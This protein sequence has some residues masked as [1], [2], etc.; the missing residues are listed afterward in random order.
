MGGRLTLSDARDA[1]LDARLEIVEIERLRHE[2]GCASSPYAVDLL[3][4]RTADDD[5]PVSHRL[6]GQRH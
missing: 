3:V 6:E 1:S 4:S 5:W 2:V